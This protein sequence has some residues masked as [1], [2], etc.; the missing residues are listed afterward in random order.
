MQLIEKVHFMIY[1]KKV[2]NVYLAL[3]LNF[4]PFLICFF[5]FKFFLKIKF[6]T[7]LFASLFGLVAVLPITFFQF[8]LLN[9]VPENMFESSSDLFGLFCKVL[10]L[11]GLLEEGIKTF[12]IAFVPAKKLEL[13]SFFAVSLLCGLCLGSFESMIY[14]L[15]HLSKANQEGAELLYGLIFSRMFSAD[16]IHALCAALGGLFVWGIRHKK[17]DFLTF[18]FAVL[19]HGIFN[20]FVYFNNFIHWFAVAAVLFAVIE[21]RVRYEKALTNSGKKTVEKSELKKSGKKKSD[22]KSGNKSKSVR[23]K[24]T[25][26]NDKTVVTSQKVVKSAGKTRT[27]VRKQSV[28]SDEKIADDVDVT[29]ELNDEI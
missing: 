13:R 24:R 25:D 28:K 19:C 27:K 15:Q 11:N 3:F 22:S 12:F 8:Y 23:G 4:L 17:T 14:F 29:P 26:S 7:E 21:C 2:M 5:A 1:A 9:L 16:L 20:F 18:I 6:S 10:V